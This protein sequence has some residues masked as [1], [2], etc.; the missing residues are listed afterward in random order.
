MGDADVPEHIPSSMKHP[1]EGQNSTVV[2]SI[3]LSAPP[4]PP[5]LSLIGRTKP[6]G[7]EVASWK[8]VFEESSETTSSAQPFSP[9]DAGE[10]V[11]SYESLRDAARQAAEE[12]AAM[13][14]EFE[15]EMQRKSREQALA[16]AKKRE[17][18]RAAAKAARAEA[19]AL[20]KARRE[21]VVAVARRRVSFDPACANS[22]M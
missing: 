17:K 6:A 3:D 14:A 7:R 2:A 1:D 9:Y 13:R 11:A 15:A 5:G 8:N 12:E 10:A 4:P 18:D 20:A 16:A 21:H 19:L 22:P